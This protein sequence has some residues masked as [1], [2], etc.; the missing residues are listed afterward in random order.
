MLNRGTIGSSNG[1]GEK[2]DAVLR[3]HGVGT[4]SRAKLH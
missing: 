3:S 1:M 4:G 2:P